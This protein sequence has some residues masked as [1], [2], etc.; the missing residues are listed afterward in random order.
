MLRMNKLTTEKRTEVVKMLC[1]GMS[2]RAVTRTTGVAKQTVAN[3]LVDLGLACAMYQYRKVRNL[4]PTRVE[5]DEQWSFVYSKKKNVPEK[6]AGQWGYG[7]AW[8]WKAI[9]AD[10]KLIINWLVA[11][12]DGES[13]KAFIEDLASRIGIDPKTNEP[14]RIQ[15]TTDGL[16]S[17]LEAIEQ[18]FGAGVDYA[19][20]IKTYGNTPESE[21]SQHR[22]S[23]GH[24]TGI[25]KRTITGEP[26]E[27]LM[28]TSYI[29]RANLTTRMQNRRFTR[30]T[31]GFSKKMANHE[32]MLALHFMHYNFARI[33]QTL[34][35]TPAM[36]AGVAD[37]V[38]DVSEIVALLD[39]PEFANPAGSGNSN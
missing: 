17:Y 29:E 8:V 28:S 30:L 10:S 15:L 6:F 37:H 27:A 26:S 38:W 25:E 11:P 4:H 24:C 12:R 3:L 16:N 34:R 32:A 23:P 13:A 5:A 7:D 36:E 31:N 33:H 19:M 22:Y 21:A 14:W 39:E 18:E 2:M 20:V 9:D 35:V 1:E